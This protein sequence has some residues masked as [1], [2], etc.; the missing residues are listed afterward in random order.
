MAGLEKIISQIQEE[1][2]AQV[3]SITGEAN[4]EAQ[5]I[6]EAALDRT[7]VKAV[8]QTDSGPWKVCSRAEE[9]AGNPGT[10]T[11]ADQRSHRRRQERTEIHG[12]REVFRL[13][14]KA[15]GKKRP[16]RQWKDD[17]VSGGQEASA[18]RL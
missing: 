18:S 4:A 10:K 11:G 1:S 2:R 3:Q 9:R 13:S 5:R 6:R 14:D 8:C 15:C 17:S 12:R 16:C 7:T